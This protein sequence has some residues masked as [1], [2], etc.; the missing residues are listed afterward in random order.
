MIRT[1]AHRRVVITGTGM[2]TPLGIRVRDNWEKVINGKSGIVS[3]K[4]LAYPSAPLVRL[5]GVLPKEFDFE[6]Y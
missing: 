2:I 5:G 3:I 1:V 6:K 4:D